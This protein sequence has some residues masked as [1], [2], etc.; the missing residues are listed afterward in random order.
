M[1]V[2]NKLVLDQDGLIV[3]NRQ[4][5]TSQ[6]GVYFSGTGM[7]GSDLVVSGNTTFNG[8]AVVGGDIRATGNNALHLGGNSTN[9]VYH[10]QYN[11]ACNSIDFILT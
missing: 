7:F 3:G 6:D 8:S 10:I 5:D 4:I 9:S 1:G 2:F 11:A